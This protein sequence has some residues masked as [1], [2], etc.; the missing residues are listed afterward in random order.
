MIK[1]SRKFTRPFYFGFAVI[2]GVINIKLDL[3]FLVFCVLLMCPSAALAY[4]DPSAGNALVYIALTLVSVI[5]FALKGLYY[6]LMG[7]STNKYE[8]ANEIVI[9]SEGK[10]YWNTFEPIV[11]ALINRGQ[12]FSYYTMDT[13]DPGLQIQNKLVHNRY[14]GGGYI[15]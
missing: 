2:K 8:A 7:K 1:F 5:A 3:L 11:Q 9:F 13:E 12:P 10:N 14:V 15:F 6:R 4:L